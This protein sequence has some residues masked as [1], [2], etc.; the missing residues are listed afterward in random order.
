LLGLFLAAS[1]FFEQY[2]LRGLASAP[3]SMLAVR[4]VAAF[5]GPAATLAVVL[6]IIVVLLF[7][8]GRLPSRRWRPVLWGA[9]EVAVVGGAGTLL[10]RGTV[11]SGSLTNALQAAR[12]AY[13]NPLG[14]FPRQGWYGALLA[15]TAVI[16]LVTALLAVASV[17][18]RRRRAAA[19]L[20]QQLAWLA[21]VGVLFLAALA[22]FLADGI[23][24]RGTGG[25]LLTFL[26]VLAA[27]IALLGVPAA[28]VVAVLKYRLYD[29]DVVVR[30][31]VVAGLVAGT[32]TVIYA[33][34]VLGAGALA[35]RPGNGLLTFT[36]AA[37][38]AVLLQPV[39]ARAGRL[40][41]HLVY[42]RRATPYE[43]LSEFSERMAG[44]SP[45]EDV[46]PRMA[47]MLTEAT[48]AEQAQVWLRAAGAER[49]AAAWLAADGSASRPAGPESVADDGRTRVFA[50]EHQGKRLGSLRITSSLREP[51]TPAGGT[52]GA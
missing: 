7:P 46:L 28:C 22:A 26:F 37:I 42:G 23:R 2:G 15:V 48:G 8:D 4:Q 27:A 39:R 49:L 47:R 14:V 21:Y 41:D 38:A 31:T 24:T 51:L 43:V 1:L 18:A 5:G 25:L 11:V 29:L 10:Q 52:A 16:A 40:A 19:E 44:T 30:K 20:R 45:T 35:G 3:G 13:P 36:A 32:F 6:L 9:I 12:V 17:F 34:V 50:V 33:L